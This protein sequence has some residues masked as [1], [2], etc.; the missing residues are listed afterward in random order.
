M[1]ARQRFERTVTHQPVD[2]VL[3]DYGK[4]IG[5][6]HR[7]VY[8]KLRDYLGLP[9]VEIKILDRMAQNV[10]I[11]EDVLQA[12]DVDFRWIVPKWVNV[13]EIEL[14]GQPGYVDMWHT[15]H[16]YTD[17][18]GYY[19]VAGQPLDMERMTLED[20]EQFDWPDPANPEMFRGLG[21]EARRWFENSDFIVGADGI[22]A[23]ILQ[24][25][26]QL[27]GYDKL[28][29][30][31]ALQPE[32]VSAF[33]DR[34]STT[35][36]EMYA[37]YLEIVGPYVQVVVI[38]DDQGTQ[39][40]LMI[41]PKMFRR[42]IKPNLKKIIDTIKRHSSAKVLMHCDGAILPIIDDLIEIGVDILNPVQ[43]SAKGLEDTQELKRRFG[44]RLTFHGSIDVQQF[45]PK[46]T[47]E[48]VRSEVRRRIDE[49]GQ[50]GGF[51]LAP[52]HNIYDDIPLENILALFRSQV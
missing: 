35:I 20:I 34:L 23:G 48:K 43:T 51:I 22:K 29:M 45:L 37:R 8:G 52:C 33:L 15:P 40:S 46:A 26:S 30:D 47:P 32:I 24:T 27:R 18:G 50:S 6:F 12:L 11:D 49:L 4:H 38:T 7:S 39:T 17:I 42:F 14:D 36:S 21:E 19:A 13:R 31:F 9:P 2:R 41:S 5:S 28:F 1:S 3:V 16:K 25:A 44:D 10:V